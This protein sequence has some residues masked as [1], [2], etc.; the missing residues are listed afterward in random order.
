MRSRS[1]RT[2]RS[3][4]AVAPASP[5]LVGDLDDEAVLGD[6]PAAEFCTVRQVAT[7]RH[8]PGLALVQ[9]EPRELHVLDEDDAIEVTP[10][11][12]KKSSSDSDLEVGRCALGSTPYRLFDLK[13]PGFECGSHLVEGPSGSQLLGDPLRLG[14]RMVSP[15]GVSTGCQPV[16][17][18][19]R[20]Q[21]P[22]TRP[23]A[24][25][26][27]RHPSGGSDLFGGDLGRAQVAGE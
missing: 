5:R 18:R 24:H 16:V 20:R 14:R 2:P 25:G 4:R 11:T 3:N 15:E 27:R 9:G 1:F 22:K 19:G 8:L 7:L 17:D 13:F 23:S 6:Q 26:G 12:A 21:K 10:G